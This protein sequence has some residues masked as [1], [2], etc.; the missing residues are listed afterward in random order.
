M[1]RGATGIEGVVVG[2]SLPRH[3]PFDTELAAIVARCQAE[4]RIEGGVPVRRKR[5]AARLAEAGT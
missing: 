2:E 3:N 1:L 5:S 4:A